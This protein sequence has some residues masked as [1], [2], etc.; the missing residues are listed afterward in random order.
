MHR[1]QVL[2]PHW[3][4]EAADKVSCFSDISKGELIRIAVTEYLAEIKRDK[5]E[6]VEDFMFAARKKIEGV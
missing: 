6:D 1:T 2:F 4:N 3:L 5:F